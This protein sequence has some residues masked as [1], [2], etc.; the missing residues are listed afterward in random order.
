MSDEAEFE[1]AAAYISTAAA[2]VN[3]SVKLE[4]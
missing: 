3:D 1:S 4:V 2:S